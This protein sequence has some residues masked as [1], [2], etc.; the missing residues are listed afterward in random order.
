MKL[1]ICLISFEL[2]P[3]HWLGGEGTYTAGLHDS[4]SRLGYPTTT[5]VTDIGIK[6]SLEAPRRSD[7]I[8][9]PTIN[10]RPLRLLSFYLKANSRI[11]KIADSTRPMDVVHY[12]NDYCGPILSE[13]DIHKPVIV[14]MHHPYVAERNSSQHFRIRDATYRLAVLSK[15]LM[16]R[17]A[18]KKATRIIAVS[19]FTAKGIS[20]GYG[21]SQDKITVIPDGVDANRFN[22]EV[23]GRKIRGLWGVNSEPLVVFV[24]RL[25]RNKGLDVLIEAFGKV[26]VESSE[27]KLVIV[28]EEAKTEFK[29]ET[30]LER[31]QAI[32]RKLD[33][34]DSVKFAGRVSEEDL[35]EVYASA[36]L[37]VL[38]S[39]MEGFGMVLLEAM[40]TSKPCVSTTVGGVPEVVVDGETGT[41]VRPGDSQALY[42]AISEILKD[43]SLSR[44]LGEAGRA[45]VEERFAWDAVARKTVSLYAELLSARSQSAT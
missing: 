13:E 23:S 11:R 28:G 16:A 27:A 33:L 2:P 18:C 24:G 30:I 40:A 4:F 26:L 12:T 9:V 45:R 1:R 38:P 36:D 3:F 31:L 19:K 37:V 7:V 14:T 43:R 25:A 35:P 20:S 39:F 10:R 34:Q 44:R 8:F 29:K 41:L 5:L 6:S 15:S 21:I 22:P 32:V 42:R 17:N